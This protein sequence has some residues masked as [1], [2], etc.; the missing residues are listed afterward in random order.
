MPL[1]KEEYYKNML[2]N[3]KVALVGPSKTI[4]GTGQGKKIDSYDI[5]VRL[6]RALSH[7]NGKEQDLGERTDILFACLSTGFVGQKHP[8]TKKLEVDIGQYEKSK[9]Q[10]I[11][12]AF[13]SDFGIKQNVNNVLNNSSLK[14]REIPTQTYAKIKSLAACHPN[15]G[16][17]AI[18]D[19][20]GTELEELFI[21]G[22]DF[23][24]TT[25]LSDYETYTWQEQKNLFLHSSQHDPDKQFKYFKYNVYS[26]DSR[27]TVDKSLNTFLSDKKYELTLR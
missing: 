27:V 25:Y 19:L 10:L 6:N 2:K 11:S 1:V 26:K 21:T 18:L 13:P 3:K 5:V 14:L 20:L 17:I 24:R 4:E 9:I 7:L 15:T 22:L 23:H 16:F 8:R 12:T